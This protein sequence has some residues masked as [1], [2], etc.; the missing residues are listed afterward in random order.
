M[1]CSTCGSLGDVQIA[2]TAPHAL[3]FKLSAPLDTRV[4]RDCMYDTVH[5]HYI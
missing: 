4:D 1:V 5:K 2:M 3:Q